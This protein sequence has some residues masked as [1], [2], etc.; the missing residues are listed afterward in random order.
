M[1]ISTGKNVTITKEP[2]QCKLE[3]DG[4]MIKQVIIYYCSAW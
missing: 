4:I 3:E 2:V 1:E